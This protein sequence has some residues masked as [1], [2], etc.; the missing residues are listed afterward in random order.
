M[1]SGS[2][3]VSRFNQVP[4]SRGY[5]TGTPQGSD[6]SPLTPWLSAWCH[7]CFRWSRFALSSLQC[8][9]CCYHFS[10]TRHVLSHL[11]KKPTCS[12]TMFLF[13]CPFSEWFLLLVL[14]S[15]F[16]DATPIICCCIKQQFNYLDLF[17]IAS[18]SS[19]S[20]SNFLNIYISGCVWRPLQVNKKF[21]S[22]LPC[23]DMIAMLVS[24]FT[25]K[26]VF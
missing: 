5:R 17:F 9:V 20:S 22:C 15:S 24:L 3:Q 25:W 23:K 8:R 19:F 7:W 1:E 26:N 6:A 14:L 11:Q 18:S 4:A 21:L 16:P 2:Q 13:S 12:L 10:N